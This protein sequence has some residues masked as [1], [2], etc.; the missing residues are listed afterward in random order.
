MENVTVNAN[1]TILL[2]MDPNPANYMI[3]DGTVIAE[4]TRD[5]VI[6]AKSIHIRAGNISA[7]SAQSPFT[8]NFLIRINNT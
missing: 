3:I 2:D 5:V 7:G 1:W 4:D 6:T 8:H